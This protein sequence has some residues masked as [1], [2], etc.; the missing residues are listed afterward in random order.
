M[1]NKPAGVLT[2]PGRQGGESIREVLER[3]TGR[4]QD[5]RLVHRLDRQTSG[6]LVLAKTVDAQRSLSD[7]F[8][9]HKVSK[10]YLAIVAGSPED[11]SGLIH[12]AIAPHPRIAG[13]MT[14]AA[15]GKPSQT[16]WR[17]VERFGGI[18]V[19][20]CWPL[21]GRQHQIR[22]HLKLMAMPLLVDPLYGTSDAFYLSQIKS[23]YRTSTRHDERP[24]IARLTLH[25]EAIS[26]SHPAT[27]QPVYVEA[28]LPKDFRATLSQLRKLKG[29][30]GESGR[31]GEGEKP[32]LRE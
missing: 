31:R 10:Q 18:S 9:H 6:V 27:A 19:V 13:R 15:R 14:I 32:R 24:L 28:S 30:E 4:P 12:A 25:A 1:V 7:Q 2:V 26:F 8:F 22:V 21:T 11:D 23:D 17:V 5:F 16:R 20:R 3:Q 29:G